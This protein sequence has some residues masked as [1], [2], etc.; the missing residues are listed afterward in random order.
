MLAITDWIVLTCLL[1][2]A[3]VALPPAFETEIA[4]ILT[5]A[6]CNSGACHGSAAGRGNFK[7]SLFGGDL[8]ADYDA[9]VRQFE[10]RRVSYTEPRYSLVVAKPS[11]WEEHGGG[12]RFTDDS[13]EYQRLVAWIAAGT[14]RDPT[15]RFVQLVIEPSTAELAQAPEEITLRVQADLLD[16][17][18][19]KIERREVTRQSTFQT[20]DE[21]GAQVSSDGVVTLHRGGRHVVIARFLNLVATATFTAPLK[22][23]APGDASSTQLPAAAPA[24]S[25][26]AEMVDAEIDAL[27][28]ALRLAAA[29]EAQPEEQLRRLRLHL[30]GRLP[31]RDEIPT[32]VADPAPDRYAKLVDRLLTSP[33]FDVYWTHY[34]SQ[35]LRVRAPVNERQASQALQGWLQEQ[36]RAG[37]GLDRVAR[38]LLLAEG[39]SHLYGP[40]AFYRLGGDAR[41]TAEYVSEVLLGVRLRCANCHNHPLD[42]WTQDDYHGLAAIFARVESGRNVR[43]TAKGEVVHPVT[44]RAAVPRIPGED[45]LTPEQMQSDPRMALADWLTS[46]NNPYF[47]RAVVNRVWKQLMGRGLI[48]PADDLRVTNPATHPRLLQFLADDFV[49]SG[50]DLRHLIRTIVHSAA[51]RRSSRP[52]TDSGDEMFYSHYFPRALSPEVLVDAIDD[53]TGVRSQYDQMPADTRA[54]ALPD[55]GVASPAL[56]VLGRCDRTDSCE[57]AS[58]SATGLSARL[59]LLNGPLLNHKIQAPAG[60]LHTM[61]R[62]GWDDRRIVREFYL[63]ALSREPSAEELEFLIR[64]TAGD[65]RTAVLEDF[66]WSLLNCQ[67][68]VTNH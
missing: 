9:I 64:Q 8:D 35:L 1:G 21:D 18:T 11:G 31:E 38:D 29:G 44:G 48:E 55:P 36:M 57:S 32:F 34:L 30:T 13:D 14:P 66:V 67:E 52:V 62:D 42:H 40:A 25:P 16:R 65:E 10:G 37:T 53:V 56:D 39:D 60:R 2:S 46:D 23:G 12:E 49:A 54:I 51:Y 19:G 20:G 59:H 47:A 22:A 3:E 63:R 33:E 6:G 4:P 7:L 68:F 27:L 26:A 58:A 28:S 15:R 50:Y 5:R 24:A 17:A 61:L 41:G 43:I 45:F